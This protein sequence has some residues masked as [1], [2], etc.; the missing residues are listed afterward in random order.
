MQVAEH[1]LKTYE[2]TILP[3][4]KQQVEVALSSYEAGRSDILTLIDAQ[5]T[6]RDAQIAYYKFAADYE[7]GLSDLRLAV[8]GDMTQPAAQGGHP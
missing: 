1:A 8:G 2:Q 7:L 5:R 3:Q 4:A 6:L